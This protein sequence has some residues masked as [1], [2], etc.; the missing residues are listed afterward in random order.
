[1]HEKKKAKIETLKRQIAEL[2]DGFSKAHPRVLVGLSEI[3]NAPNPPEDGVALITCEVGGKNVR[4]VTCK[5]LV[6]AKDWLADVVA[7]MSERIRQKR[8]D[9]AGAVLE[10]K[11]E[12]PTITDEELR[13][14][15]GDPPLNG[16]A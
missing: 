15:L 4:K 2:V 3:N 11:A 14:E 13:A 1:M 7:P 12:K 6:E 16:D 8:G 9:W 5:D 10:R